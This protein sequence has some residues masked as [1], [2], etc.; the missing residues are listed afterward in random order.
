ME[1]TRSAVTAG[2]SPADGNGDGTPHRRRGAV[3]VAE[4]LVWRRVAAE[5]AAAV[6]ELGEIGA[7]RAR[8]MR[9][10]VGGWAGQ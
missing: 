7:T 1:A 9:Y 6:M 2:F 5:V 3:A 10:G 4:L 8:G